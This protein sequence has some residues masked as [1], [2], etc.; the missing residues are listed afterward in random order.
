MFLSFRI[1]EQLALAMKF[2]KPGGVASPRLARLWLLAGHK[3]YLVL[4]LGFTKLD[5][6]LPLS[7]VLLHTDRGSAVAALATHAYL[8]APQIEIWSTAIPWSW[9]IFRMSSVAA[10]LRHIKGWVRNS[11]SRVNLVEQGISI[12]VMPWWRRFNS[13]W[14]AQGEAALGLQRKAPCT[15][16]NASYWRLSADGSGPW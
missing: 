13:L 1:F 3:T 6:S 14:L 16:V 2:F 8:H 4:T 12:V 9:S 15:N 7:V 10:R 5:L 11:N